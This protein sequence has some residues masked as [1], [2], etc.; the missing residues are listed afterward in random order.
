MHM[1]LHCQSLMSSVGKTLVRLVHHT[2]RTTSMAAICMQELEPGLML[3]DF[4]CLACF[5]TL[6]S[7]CLCSITIDQSTDTEPIA[8]MTS[9]LALSQLSQLTLNFAFLTGAGQHCFYRM[10]RSGMAV[11]IARGILTTV[12]DLHRPVRWPVLSELTLDIDM[13]WCHATL[14]AIMEVICGLPSLK[15]LALKSNTWDIPCLRER[16]HPALMH[17]LQH[18][19][20]RSGVSVAFSGHLCTE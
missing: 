3:E 9:L 20:T 13:T 5:P 19:A 14:E 10:G 12:G 7:V 2:A 17:S 6:K 15:T 8:L 18:I 11:P 16:I 4:A 1:R